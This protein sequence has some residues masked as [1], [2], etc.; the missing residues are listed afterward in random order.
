MASWKTDYIVKYH[1][2]FIH[3]DGRIEVRNDSLF[4]EAGSPEEVEKIVLEQFDNSHKP[5]IEF[6]E[7]WLDKLTRKELEIDEI[8]MLWKY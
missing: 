2:T 7:N 8:E 3:T 4:I 5:L 6:P 1:I